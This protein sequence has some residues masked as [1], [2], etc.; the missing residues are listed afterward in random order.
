MDNK[1]RRDSD[2]PGLGPLEEVKP[3]V[4]LDCIDVGV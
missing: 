2:Y 1:E 4:L 3:Y